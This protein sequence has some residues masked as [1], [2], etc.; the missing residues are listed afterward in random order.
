MDDLEEIWLDMVMAQE[1]EYQPI[2]HR[3]AVSVVTEAPVVVPGA[4][5]GP[6]APLE[7]ALP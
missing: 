3:V 6:D 1:R 2:S 7:G 5:V 4:V